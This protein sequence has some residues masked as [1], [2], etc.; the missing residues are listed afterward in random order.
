MGSVTY[1][2]KTIPV[3]LPE[4]QRRCVVMVRYING[5]GCINGDS[6]HAYL[7]LNYATASTTI[8]RR[9][10]CGERVVIAFSRGGCD[11]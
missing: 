1:I 3:A 6:K 4:Q 2:L 10:P 11:G 9:T 7:L 5:V 8:D